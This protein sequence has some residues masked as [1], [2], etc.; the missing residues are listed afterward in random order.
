MDR[1]FADVKATDEVVAMLKAA[2]LDIL[3]DARSVIYQGQFG[4]IGFTEWNC[5]SPCANS[6]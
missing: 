4:S 2:I 3:N 1:L 6:R 5:T